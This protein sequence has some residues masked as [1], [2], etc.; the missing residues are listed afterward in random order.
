M[1]VKLLDSGLYYF[2]VGFWIADAGVA[3]LDEVLDEPCLFRSVG[4]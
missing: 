4:L 3:V 2:L 1:H